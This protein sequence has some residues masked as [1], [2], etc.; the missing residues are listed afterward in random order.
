MD[1]YYKENDPNYHLYRQ[2]YNPQPK[3]VEK[4]GCGQDIIFIAAGVFIIL[5]ILA[6][7]GC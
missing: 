6:L 3:R 1:N 7:C 4:K 5:A 2:P